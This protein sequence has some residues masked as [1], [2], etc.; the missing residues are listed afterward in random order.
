M[1]GRVRQF[2]L[3][4]RSL[5]RHEELDGELGAEMNTHLGLAIEE[6]IQKG[7]SPEEARR[8]ALIR[9]GGRER[10]REEHRESRTWPTL[11]EF[12]QDLRYALRSF[13]RDRSFVFVAILILALGIGANIAVFSVV[14]TILLRPL[15]FHD[16]KQLVFISGADGKSGMSS[17][18]YSVDAYEEYKRQ[19]QSFVDVTGYFAFSS[20]NNVK[21]TQHGDSLPVSGI[22]V[23]S[24]IF[25]TLGVQPILG[26]SFAPEECQ[27]NSQ[28]VAMLS[29]AFWRRQFASNP[30]IVGQ[31]I[32]LDN[33]PVT[34][35]G[36]LPETFDFGSVF[37]PGSR[38]DIF[39]PAILDDMRDWGNTLALI[40]RL[41]PD[42]SVPQA[43]AEA[44]IAFPRLHF[45]Q[46]HPEWGGDYTGRLAELKEYVTGKLRRSL[47]V[48]WSAVGLI[49][50]I[51]CV[52]LANL[53]VARAGAR[54]K[55]F[56]MRRALGAGRGRLIRQLLAE[57]LLL[58]AWGAVFGLGLAFGIVRYLAHQDAIALP[59]LSSLKIDGAALVW[60]VVIS[61]AAAVFFGLL[62]NIKI[63]SGNLQEALKDS[64]AGMTQGR[65]HDRMRAVLVVSE[66][67][68]ACVL[69]V[70]AGLLLR[71]FLHVLDV[72]LGFQPSR[73]GAITVDYD[74]GGKPEKRSAILQN[75]LGRIRAIPGIESASIADNLPLDRNRAW[76]LSA[77]GKDYRKG[78]LPGAF[79]YIT[80]PG[81]FDAMGMQ[82]R[83]GGISPGRTLPRVN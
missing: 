19:N 60:T 17:I 81:Y 45:S 48:L 11:D 40:G 55:E 39:M 65:K 30:S 52:N 3:R 13:R 8:Q 6:N 54:S 70:G 77:K 12:Q 67:A 62:P 2:V 14:N 59:L 42:I 33:K 41:K 80:T 46:K 68:L 61:V 76:G 25:P 66:M 63:S 18:T 27:K 15:P 5:F 73:A 57:I 35:V 69:L 24:N 37:F 78:E 32:T 4:L 1:N 20:S 7:M 50:L 51:V 23:V 64:S 9:F 26:R 31:P 28:P 82:I 22:L 79:V 36:V 16:S 29:H 34:V 58:S 44:N 10:A 56:A 49:L 43:Q 47:V 74:D 53:L 83:K 38:I 21:L 72:D 71:S 75:I